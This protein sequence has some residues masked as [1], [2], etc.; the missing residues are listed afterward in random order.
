V[1]APV[2]DQI[3][4]HCIETS[5]NKKFRKCC[6]EKIVPKVTQMKGLV[7]VGR[8][9]LNQHP[10]AFIRQTVYPFVLG[11]IPESC[12]PYAV[13]DMEVE[14]SFYYVETDYF[15]SVAGEVFSDE[16]A[17]LLRAFSEEL[18][19]WKTN[20]RQIALKFLPGRLQ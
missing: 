14:K 2:V 20:K 8:R 1:N 7:G 5:E 3:G 9:K 4:F 11:K 12:C 15:P 19:E 17:D 6:P 18:G 13:C 10:L 16:V